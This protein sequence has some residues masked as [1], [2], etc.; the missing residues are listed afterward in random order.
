M[1][2]IKFR[3]WHAKSKQMFYSTASASNML[4]GLDGSVKDVYIKEDL[5]DEMVK[6]QYTGLKD[7]NDKE[8]YEG[9][10][11]SY[12]QSFDNSELSK[13]LPKSVREIAYLDKY[14]CFEIMGWFGGNALSRNIKTIEVIGNIYENPELLEAK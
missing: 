3:L 5:T 8:I 4:I 10:I 2:E 13:D 1:R 11:V 7:K 6:M 12:P 9:D 14:A